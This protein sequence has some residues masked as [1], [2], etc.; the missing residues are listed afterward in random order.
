MAYEETSALWDH[1]K[2]QQKHQW[3]T[4]IQAVLPRLSLYIIFKLHNLI[5][6]NPRT[7]I[8][9]QVGHSTLVIHILASPTRQNLHLLPPMTAV[10]I[11]HP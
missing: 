7:F 8:Q 6:L 9:R 11:N 10:G 1:L 2:N 5:R 3:N 4:C